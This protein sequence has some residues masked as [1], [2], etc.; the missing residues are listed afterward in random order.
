MMSDESLQKG[1]EYFGYIQALKSSEVFWL[2]RRHSNT[3]EEVDASPGLRSALGAP[4]PPCHL[5]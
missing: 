4:Q 1:K 2:R 5:A 3:R